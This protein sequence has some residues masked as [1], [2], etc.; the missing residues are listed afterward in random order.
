MPYIKQ[1]RR[2]KYEPLINL[3]VQELLRQTPSRKG[4]K[5]GE[6][7]YVIT[8]LLNLLVRKVDLNYEYLS[9]LKNVLTDVQDE[10]NEKVMK[11]YEALQESLNGKIYPG[12]A[13]SLYS[14]GVTI[15]R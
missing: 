12:I 6:V 4:P 7:N 15:I 9:S 5:L 13:R 14:S 8:S 1:D 3:L 2:V 10:F 11:P